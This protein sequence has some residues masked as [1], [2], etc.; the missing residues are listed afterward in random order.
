MRKPKS[1]VK[2]AR[3]VTRL[4]SDKEGVVATIDGVKVKILNLYGD[5]FIDMH[6][7]QKGWLVCTNGTDVI[8]VNPRNVSKITID[9]EAMAYFKYRQA[10]AKTREAKAKYDIKCADSGVNILLNDTRHRRLNP[11]PECQ[12]LNV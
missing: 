12:M 4:R 5:P 6:N 1:Q 2:Q 3:V 11:N 8:F 7:I 10:P 9:M